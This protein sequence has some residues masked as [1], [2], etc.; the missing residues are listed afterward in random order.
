MSFVILC[1]ENRIL[2]EEV[3]MKPWEEISG[4]VRALLLKKELED[5]EIGQRWITVTPEGEVYLMATFSGDNSY[6]PGDERAQL[7]R[8]DVRES[9]CYG[10]FELEED[11]NGLILSSDDW[12]WPKAFRDERSRDLWEADAKEFGRDCGNRYSIIGLM[13][14]AEAELM[15]LAE[16]QYEEFCSR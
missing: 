15:E 3:Q 13:P 6:I 8:S 4:Q 2:G 12:D 5:M 9:G 1:V 14:E 10:G 16:A 11:E 7:L